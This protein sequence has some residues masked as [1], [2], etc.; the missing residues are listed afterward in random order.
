M[1]ARCHCGYT[2]GLGMKSRSPVSQEGAIAARCVCAG[3]MHGACGDP[4]VAWGTTT[5]SRVPAIE[6]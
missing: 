3:T 1:S 4:D 5:V 6:K 2:R